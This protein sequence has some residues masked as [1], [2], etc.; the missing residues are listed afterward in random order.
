MNNNDK[1]GMVELRNKYMEEQVEAQSEGRTIPP[2]VQWVE[3]KKKKDKLATLSMQPSN[4][5]R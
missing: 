4:M 2:F 1:A 5:V 3:A